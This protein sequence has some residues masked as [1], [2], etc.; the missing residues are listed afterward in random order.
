MSHLRNNKIDCI[1]AVLI[2][3][4]NFLLNLLVRAI[5]DTLEHLYFKYISVNYEDMTIAVNHS[6][7]IL[8][9]TCSTEYKTFIT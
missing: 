9:R 3:E 5:S 7:Y 4:V 8:I 2:Y 6:V 1:H